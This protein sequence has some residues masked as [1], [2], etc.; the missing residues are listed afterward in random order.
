M[1]T[2]KF[3]YNSLSQ[4]EKKIWHFKVA[5]AVAPTFIVAL[6]MLSWIFVNSSPS[7]VD[8]CITKKT[9]AYIEIGFSAM[10]VLKRFSSQ[11]ESTCRRN[12]DDY[13]IYK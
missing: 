6:G 3:D 10:E 12:P 5:L 2:Q 1:T 7:P 9:R 4:E 11:I 13:N 8:T